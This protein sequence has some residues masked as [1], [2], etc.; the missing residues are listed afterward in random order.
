MKRVFQP[1]RKKTILIVDDDHYFIETSQDYFQRHGFKVESVRT[2]HRILERL[3]KEKVDFLLIDLCLPGAN[4][5]EVLKNIRAEFDQESL[6]IIAFA[7]VLL[8]SLAREA[9]EAGATRC[10]TKANNSSDRLLTVVRQLLLPVS[11]VADVILPAPAALPA[12]EIALSA[13]P[14][15]PEKLA[16]D[17]SVH[18]AEALSELRASCQAFARPDGED[19]RNGE[20]E[21][22]H[23]HCR[24]L[25]GTSRPLGLRDITQMADAVEALI[26]EARAKPQ[27]I[28]P[29][30]IRTFLQAI[31]TLT[32]LFAQNGSAHADSTTPPS[33]LVVD[34]EMIS[35]EA[36]CS[37][38]RKAEL[39]AKSLGDSVAAAVLLEEEH[40]DLI[41]LDVEMPGRS[42]LDLCSDLRKAATN[43]D[44]PVVFV[45]A[46]SDFVSWSK[47][48]LSGGNDFIAKPFLSVELAV[49]ALSWLFK[50]ASRPAP[51]ATLE[52]AV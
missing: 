44:T 23:R 43:R 2:P 46:H 25:S 22:M 28:T 11:K 26:I 13:E 14:E 1:T 48:S 9:M 8:G 18:G 4:G 52:L 15:F 12:E 45:T 35:R 51:A 24:T 21:K 49:K 29:S 33:I 37:A 27:K 47:T 20:L 42:G 41:F 30:V 40:F 32:S 38:L 39:G 34:D 10:L 19:A 5:T 7:N 17:F 36:I 50:A 3:R 16:L 6:P 31:D